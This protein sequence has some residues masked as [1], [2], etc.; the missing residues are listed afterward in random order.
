MN[1]I[2]KITKWG[3]SYGV[4]IPVAVLRKAEMEMNDLVYIETDRAGFVSITKKPT[5]KKGT[6]EYLFKDYEGEKFDTV[7]V[8]LGDAV[9]EEKW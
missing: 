8:D 4:R 9:G 2:V 1:N 3:N 6:I 5:V 7:L